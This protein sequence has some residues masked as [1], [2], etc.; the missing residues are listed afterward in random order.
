MRKAFTKV[1]GLTIGFALTVGVAAGAS[2]MNRTKTVFA[3]TEASI[4][5]SSF[6]WGS[7][8]G[9][10]VGEVNAAS[11]DTNV[12]FYTTGTGNN[13]K[14][15]SDW[16]LYNTGNGNVIVKAYNGFA[17]TSITYTFT[18]ANSGCLSNSNGS[19][20]TSL[21]TSGTAVSLSNVESIE[22][23]VANTNASTNGQVRITN[24]EVS[25]V[26]TGSGDS[27][28]PEPTTYTVSFNGNGA[29][30]SMEDVEDVSGSYI[31]PSNSFTVPSGK[32]FAGWKAN[33][34][35]ALIAAG[36][37]Y[38]VNANV[39]FYAQWTDLYSVVYY[40][41]GGFGSITDNNS[42]YPSGSHVTVAEN[43]FTKPGYDFVCFNTAQDGSGTSYVSGNVFDITSNTTLY[44]QWE[45]TLTGDLVTDTFVQSDFAATNNSYTVFS[46][47]DQ[48][49]ATYVGY[50]AKPGSPNTGF[51][52]LNK[53]SSSQNRGISTSVSGGHIRRIRVSWGNSNS[54]SFSV[55][56]NDT[57]YA[58]NT[59]GASGTLK[60]TLD[61]NH[62]SVTIA[63]DY[64]YVSL[65]ANGA[66]YPASVTFIWERVYL[67][68]T[69]TASSASAYDDQTITIS[70]DATSSV[71]WT[72]V[73]DEDTTADGASVTAGGVVSV[74]GPG[75][76]KI[77]AS[78]S[79]YNDETIQVTFIERP[80]GTYYDVLFDS[81]GGS[82]S[83]DP[84]EVLEGQT[85]IFPSPGTKE[86]YSFVGWTSDLSDFYDAGD[87]SPE[88]TDDVEYL[89]WWE[90]D[91]KYTVTYTA[92]SNGSGSY[93]HANNYG[94]TYT[95]LAF[96]SLGISADSG[97]RFKD[98]TVGGVHKNPGETFELS[99]NTQVTV[100]FEELPTIDTLDAA[101]IGQTS[102]GNWSGKTDSSYA[103]YSGNSTESS[104]H[105]IQM[106]TDNNNSG[107]VST[108]SGGKIL[109][110][111][112]SWNTDDGQANARTLDVYAKN[113]PYSAATDLYNNDLKGT[114]VGS[115]SYTNTTS[116]QTELSV[117]G[118][119]Q[120]VGVRSSNKALYIDE[121]SFE[122][123]QTE[124]AVIENTTT[125]M[126]ALKFEYKDNGDDTFSYRN[127][128]IRFGGLVSQAQW[129][130]LNAESTI[131]GYGVLIGATGD[132]DGQTIKQRYYA[133]KTNENSPE[134]AIDSICSAY[135][136]SKKIVKIPDDK[137]HPATATADQKT[138]MGAGA[139]D[140][141]IWNVK[142]PF[143]DA[144]A[145]EYSSV[146]FILIDGDIVFL[147][148]VSIS[149]K[150]IATRDK[151]SN[152]A[153]PTLPV[154]EY[155][156]NHY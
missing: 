122:W 15:Y 99:A 33:N 51:I 20:K 146:A 78:A 124:K 155:I 81:D 101:S 56:V 40:G 154:F 31:L 149:A 38:T 120:Y 143:E 148:E 138:F 3:D 47:T 152:P 144:F 69:L 41:N 7:S 142:K 91:A 145:I 95:L 83:P 53:F 68:Q 25:Y 17:L 88:V 54:N 108:T 49:D 22:Y 134:E 132:L 5:M 114:K 137:E 97:Y 131:E 66:I 147:Q 45:E 90:E 23:K 72:V 87:T 52:Q 26:S 62:L 55:Y 80:A 2:L 57:A 116:Y 34:A 37:S 16:R 85:F 92:G 71:T 12:K 96:N 61:A 9:N 42:P 18:T 79:G 74:D 46:I 118:N 60:G 126:S 139:G 39:T 133:A 24:I 109:K 106:R 89:A 151:P 128:A 84:I 67:G 48:S 36:A 136:L 10:A 11:I 110:V 76:V 141:Y 50:S 86:H 8:S 119:Y 129:A 30:G 102:Y 140:Y 127:T 29:E 125:T 113:S 21:V 94:G 1:V 103:T 4:S 70:S 65:A 93:N 82:N 123:R 13:G 107:I 43:A 27:S 73:D 130:A 105:A 58:N 135:S 75:T 100:N 77:K 153:D 111:V 98:Y 117:S 59:T 6:G 32:V 44:A 104:H 112:V 35:G 28:E 150:D 19:N 63:G 156:E 14:Y 64:D 121:I 115:I